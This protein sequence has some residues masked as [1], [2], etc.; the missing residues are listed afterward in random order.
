MF[1][2]SNLRAME[3]IV[4]HV[5]VLLSLVMLT[6][7]WK[8]KISNLGKYP[9]EAEQY[10]KWHKPNVRTT[11]V[12]IKKAL[13]ECGSPAP[14]PSTEEYKAVGYIGF[15]D[16]LNQAFLIYKCMEKAGYIDTGRYTVKDYCL[17]DRHQ[18]LPACQPEAVI[19]TPSVERRLNSW[20]CKVKSD[21]EYCLRNALAPKLCSRERVLNPP[22]ECLPSGQEHKPSFDA[23]SEREI[24]TEAY[25][26]I[27]EYP[28]K[29]LRLQQEMQRDSN[30]Q[31]DKLLRDT[32]PKI[33]R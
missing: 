19:S 4:R 11:V 9:T 21:Y 12:D 14:N 25:A 27:K 16:Q 8:Y 30:R 15:D 22:P 5:L 29:P 23:R 18:N 17:W 28:E 7:C 3:T 6:G 33:H 1:D 13:L 20:Y 32:A 31:M 10:G 26:P 2:H 24:S